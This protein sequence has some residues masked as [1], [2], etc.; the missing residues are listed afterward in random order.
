[1]AWWA[2]Y[3]WFAPWN[4][5]RRTN[6]VSWYKG[7][8]YEQWFYSLSEE[9]QE[10]ELTRLRKEKEKRERES[11]AALRALA[12]ITGMLYDKCGGE[13]LDIARSMNFKDVKSKYW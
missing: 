5:T 11:R 10:A 4:K 1:M 6:W 13:Y 12:N 8:L 9:E 3:K 7:Y 2:L